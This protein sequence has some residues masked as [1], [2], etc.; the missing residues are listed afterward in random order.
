M[1]LIS[2]HLSF[3]VFRIFA[4]SEAAE[5]SKK[6]SSNEEGFSVSTNPRIRCQ[7]CALVLTNCYIRCAPML[8]LPRLQGFS[9]TLNK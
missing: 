2:P 7:S 1:S 8:V 6:P 3:T 5:D 4:E 9:I